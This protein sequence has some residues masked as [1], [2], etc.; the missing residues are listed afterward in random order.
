VGFLFNLQVQVEPPEEAAEASEPTRAASDGAPPAEPADVPAAPGAAEEPDK[1]PEHPTIH[2]KGLGT[3]ARPRGLTYTAP[4][5][6]GGD[7]LATEQVTETV[8]DTT[9]AGT[10]RNALCPCGSGRKY[11]RCHGDPAKRAQL[12]Q[13]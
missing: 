11:K 5:I 10:P 6:D 12:L 7:G 3:P 13:G 2:A 8:D 4:T 1:E 9:Y